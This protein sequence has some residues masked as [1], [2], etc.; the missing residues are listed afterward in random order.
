MGVVY[1]ARDPQIG[2]QLAIKVLRTDDEEYRRRFKIE[3]NAAGGLRHRHIITVHDSGEHDGLPFLAMEYIPGETL[4]D[5]IK[6]RAELPLA[7][8][9]RY[10]EELCDGLAHAHKAGIVHRDIKPANVSSTATATR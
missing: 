4:A 5:K 7:E 8:K 9:L 3:V 6:R 2:R 10:I 1:L